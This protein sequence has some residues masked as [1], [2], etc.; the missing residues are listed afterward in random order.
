[1]VAA[2]AENLGLDH[3]RLTQNPVFLPI[4]DD[5]IYY[6]RP[7]DG[8]SGTTK[9]AD[10]KSG[11]RRRRDSSTSKYRRGDTF[12]NAYRLCDQLVS[13]G[14]RP[15]TAK[16]RRRLGRGSNAVIQEAIDSWWGDLRQRLFGPQ[17]YQLMP[18]P[19]Y[20]LAEKMYA[21]LKA[22]WRQDQK[23]RRQ[24][25]EKKLRNISEQRDRLASELSRWQTTHETLALELERT[26]NR[27]KHARE[28]ILCL[29]TDVKVLSSQLNEKEKHL[30]STQLELQSVHQHAKLTET[31]LTTMYYQVNQRYKDL[32]NQLGKHSK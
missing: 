26:Q 21:Q 1:V 28:K 8:M 15:G 24:V 13:E 5:R 6:G 17:L 14:Q 11:S 27:L 16:V 32:I 22:E 25:N 3:A 4:G 18:L 10:T 19:A 23:D 30:V 12:L 9:R 20:Q 2:Y 31:R 7:I 29:E